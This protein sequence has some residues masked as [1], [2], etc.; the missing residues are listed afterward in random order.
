MV[1]KA[2]IT[3]IEGLAAFLHQNMATK[4]DL[5]RLETRLEKK[6]DGVEK[7]LTDK[8]QGFENIAE[9]ANNKVDAVIKELGLEITS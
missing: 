7:N 4:D 2:K 3:T 9:G 5:A 6:I 1:K 8:I